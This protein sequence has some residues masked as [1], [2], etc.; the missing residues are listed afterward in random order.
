MIDNYLD[1]VTGGKKSNPEITPLVESLSGVIKVEKDF[2][3]N[4]EYANHLADKYK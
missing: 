1:S 4:R 3:Y 2:D